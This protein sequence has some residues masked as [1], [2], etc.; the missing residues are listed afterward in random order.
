[1][2]GLKIISKGELFMYAQTIEALNDDK[3]RL[4][5]E[6]NSI[7]RECAAAIEKERKRADAAVNA[8]LIKTNRVAIT[9]E[10]TDFELDKHL[11]REAKIMDIFGEEDDKKHKE[12]EQF[13]ED[14]QS[15]RTK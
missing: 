3:E 6:C 5:N 8:L 14:L 12:T 9:P 15:D 11:E 7:R 2:F 13:M 4:V 10:P 1:M